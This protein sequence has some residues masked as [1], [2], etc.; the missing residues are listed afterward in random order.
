MSSESAVT[1]FVIP[2]PF[3]R[4]VKIVRDVLAKSEVSIATELDMSARIKRELNIGFGPCR[5]LFVYSPYLLLE[6]CTLE[7]AAL[8]L[9]PLHV[10]LCGRGPQTAV[11]WMSP[12]S[13][14]GVRLPAGAS[15]PLLKLQTL[16][17]RSLERVAMRRISYETA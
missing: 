7:R 9:V 16:V 10:V 11:H 5:I 2:E 13:I 15:A 4:A 12:A 1:A 17:T 14:G 8:A 6:S 3:D